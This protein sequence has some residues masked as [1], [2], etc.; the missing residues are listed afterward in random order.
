M[1]TREDFLASAW[2]EFPASACARWAAVFFSLSVLTMVISL[3][4][5]QAFLAAA[6][7]VYVIDLWPSQSARARNFKTLP[8]L[9]P[10]VKLPLALFCL[11]SIVSV[12][13]ATDRAL[14]SFAVRKLVLFLIWL[15]AVN[16]VVSARHIKFLY[17]VLFIESAIAG[18]VGAGQF[19][20]LYRAARANHPARIYDFLTVERIHG[21]MGHWMNFG[22]QQMLVFVALA[23]FLLM[24]PVVQAGIDPGALARDS[25]LGARGRRSP[26]YTAQS[27]PGPRIPNPKS[28]FVWWAMLAVISLSIVLNFTRGVWLGCFIAVVYLT[29]RRRPRWL[30]VLP[31]LMLLGYLVA[32]SLFRQRVDSLRHPSRDPSLSIRFEMWSVGLR[33]IERHPWVGVGPNNIEL[34]YDFY[35]PSGKTAERGYHSHLH[36]N[37]LQFAAER[38]LPC[39][40]AWTWL[41]VA[42]LWHYRKIRRQLVRAHRE[43]EIW[44]VDAAIA[45]WLAIVVEGCFEFNF[46]TSPVLMLFLFMSA[47]P[48]AIAELDKDKRLEGQTGA[49]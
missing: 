19:A 5:S 26:G 29:G 13:W 18:L 27:S 8:I 38:G 47:T 41:M 10:A 42:L 2:A 23:A 46:G 1:F 25:A 22:G 7:V 44:L 32:P 6:G 37:F 9:F 17:Q 15:L 16:L 21:F 48:F 40:A 34:V 28:R 30:F 43:N 24:P 4:A 33:M 35:L 39:L 3:A 49:A 12:F 14:G 45:A 36:D 11:W 20:M 31:V